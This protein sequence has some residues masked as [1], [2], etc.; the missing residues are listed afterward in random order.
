MA[1]D[2]SMDVSVSFDFQEM[3]NAIDQAQRDAKT[4]YDL[5]DSNI[6]IELTE[7]SVKVNAQS[8]HQ[9]ESVYGII[10]QKMISRHLSPKI[11]DRQKMEEAGGMRMRQEMKLVKAL[12][13]ENAKKISKLVREN[14]EKCKPVIQGDTIR[15]SSKS[16]D[17][18]QAISKFLQEDES[19]VVPL[20]FG[21][22]K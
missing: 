13:Q 18:L 9:I 11:L 16:I 19:I 8:D 6:E 17:D 15:I 7:D 4:R 20:S 14:F 1:K 22:Y 5:K 2:H 21:N 12:D 10:V 3:R